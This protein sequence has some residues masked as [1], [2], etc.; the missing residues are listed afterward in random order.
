MIRVLPLLLLV[1]AG[2]FGQGF[3]KH[4]VNFIAGAGLPRGDL[5]N[6]LSTSGGIGFSYGYR[7]VRY[8]MAEAGYESLFGAARIRDFEPT[9]LGTL[10]IRDYQQFLPFGGRVIMPLG[11]DRVH[12]YGGGGGVYIRYSERIRQ[13]YSGWGYRVDCASCALRD[14]LGYYAVAGVNVALDQAQFLRLGAGTKVYRGA[15]SGDPLGPVPGVETRD[16]WY[17]IFAT[18]GI[19]F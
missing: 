9:A 4:H 6:V 14:G 1:A 5:N 7:P 17:T 19:S 2:T 18:V 10:R 11:D 13:P 8:L 3:R 15:T 12:V 16:H